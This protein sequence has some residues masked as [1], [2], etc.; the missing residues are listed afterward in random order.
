MRKFI[1]PLII[2][3][4][5]VGT[6]VFAKDKRVLILDDYVI[7]AVTNDT[8][9][10]EILIDLA[11]LRY[12]KDLNLPAKDIVL[13]V[14]AEYD[15][16]LMQDRN[17]AG[18]SISLSRLFPRS[19]TEI[20]FD[21]TTAPGFSSDNNSSDYTVRITQPI[22]ENAFGKVTR[23]ED[24]IIGVE[25]DVIRYQVVEAYEDYL[26]QVIAAYFDWYAAYENLRIGQS[27][28]MENLK[29]MENIERRQKASIAL[30]IDVHKIDLQVLAKQEALIELTEQY[31]NKLNFIKQA[32]RYEGDE[33]LI[34]Q[35]TSR[36]SDLGFIFE[37][38]YKRFE[39]KSR[40][41]KILDLI[42]ERNAM[43]VDQIASEFLPSID[44]LFGYTVEGDD[45]AIKNEDNMAF[46]GVEMEWPLGD[47]VKRAEYETAKID[48]KKSALVTE[49]TRQ[50]LY[51]NI[52]NLSQQINREGQLLELSEKKIDLAQSVLE[53]ET[54]NYSFG[55]VTINDYIQAVNTLDNNRFDRIR[56]EILMAKLTVE[57]LRITDQLINKKDI[58]R[59]GR[60]T[61][62]GQVE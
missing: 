56:H 16:F 11:P 43:K 6:E 37:D 32:I 7:L 44:L 47:S 31:E 40:T 23:I 24:D 9:F 62:R 52:K 3:S 28:Y 19:G 1:I 30:P 46:V 38:Q 8:T 13:G 58:K 34:P 59:T 41:Y 20:E 35:S 4:C 42:E 26:A 50:R 21:Y 49:N 18:G 57:W 36:Y 48:R 55:R 33:G 60:T 51:T 15:L 54:E 45:F 2:L 12:R 53:D 5:F 17:E 25:I 10:Q 39:E 22:A 27:S 29:L 61:D 14:A